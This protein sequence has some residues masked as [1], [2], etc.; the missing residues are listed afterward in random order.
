[1]DLI[2]YWRGP[3]GPGQF[4]TDP[5]QIEKINQAGVYLRIKLYEDE[6]SIAYIGQSLHLVTRFDQH[7]S[8]LLALQHPLRDESGEV[9]GGPGAESRF[10]ILNDVAHAGSLAIAEAQRTRFYFA[11]AQDGFDQDYLTLIEAMLKSRA[12]KVM[13]DR[14]EN[15]QNINP[16][17]FDHDI[18][19][20]SDFAEIDDQGVNLI[21]RT[22]GMEPILIPA[23]QESFENAD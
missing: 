21:E 10:Q 19:I 23:R 16:G 2:L 17:E 4:P 6:R 7:I 20:V 8:G 14:P 22:I 5:V 12:E 1:M 9:T 15:I 3:V 11:M 18:S 13:Y